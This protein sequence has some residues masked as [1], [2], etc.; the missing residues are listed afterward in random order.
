VELNARTVTFA[1]LAGALLLLVFSLM[2]ANVWLAGFS[3]V[4]FLLTVVVQRFGGVLLPFLLKQL[5]VVETRG[6]WQLDRDVAVV[7][8]GDRFLASAFLE[9]DVHFSPSRHASD[10]SVSYGAAFEKALCGL[11]FPAQFGLLVYPVDLEAYREGVLTSRL[12][13]ELSISRIK[14][15]TKPDAVALAAQERKKAM[16]ARL[17]TQLS[18]GQRPLDAV[19]YASTTAEGGSFEQAAE[20]ARF[21][22]RELKA[23]L[24]HALNLSVRTMDGD[25]LRRCLDWKVAMGSSARVDFGG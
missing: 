7:Q 22:A 10:A 9:V 16:A 18:S 12:E 21:Q 3:S 20:K 8:D 15:S 17:L 4:A 6:G 5:R 11:S 13:A 1:S 19:Y 14:Q 2:W 24:A 25:G 23:V